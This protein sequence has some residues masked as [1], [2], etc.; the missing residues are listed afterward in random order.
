M[1]EKAGGDGATGVPSTSHRLPLPTASEE[2][3]GASGPAQPLPSKQ[4]FA[5]QTQIRR[6]GPS[7]ESAWQRHGPTSSSCSHPSP[8]FSPL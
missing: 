1:G 5:F 6:Y 2:E 3:S 7:R 8:I 4:T